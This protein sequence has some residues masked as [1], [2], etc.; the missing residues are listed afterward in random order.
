M[1]PLRRAWRRILDP[2]WDVY[3]AVANSQ[4]RCDDCGRIVT[5]GAATNG[6]WQCNYCLVV[7]DYSPT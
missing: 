7:S 5:V 2:H 1:N 4:P 3:E 6:R